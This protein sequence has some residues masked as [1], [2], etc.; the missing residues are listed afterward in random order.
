LTA[1][2]SQLH[3][4]SEYIPSGQYYSWC[5][6]TVTP[7]RFVMH[8]MTVIAEGLIWA[9]H[10]ICAKTKPNMWYQFLVSWWNLAVW[11]SFAASL[12]RF[13]CQFSKYTWNLNGKFDFPLQT[14]NQNSST[15][16]PLQYGQIYFIDGWTS[17][18]GYLW[19]C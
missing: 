12:E 2:A 6:L 5:C 3:R 15:S 17:K 13:V 9:L 7:N 14:Y 11:K 19:Q 18:F 4:P 1:I 16:L 10:G 8:C